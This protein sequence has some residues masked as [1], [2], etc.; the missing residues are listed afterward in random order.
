MKT[1]LIHGQ[2]HK[3]STYHISRQL[4]DKIGNDCAEFFLPAN[5]NYHCLGCYNCLNKGRETCPH[6][7]KLGPILDSLLSADVIIIDSPTYVL[8]MTGQLKSLFDH[9]FTIWFSHRPEPAMFGKTAVVISTAAGGGMKNVTKSLAKQLFYWGVPKVY[10]LPY[11]V[12]ASSWADVKSKDKI[13]K[14]TTKLAQ[15]ITKNQR[16]PK[17]GIK[18]RFVYF[19]MKNMQKINNWSP[20]DKEHWEKHGWLGKIKPY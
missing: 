9:L 10:Q 11:R 13:E 5:F 2:N 3:G 20:L 12:A 15:K 16:T 7:D 8:E 1:T 14:E 6:Y 19:L 17:P 4:A 18:Q